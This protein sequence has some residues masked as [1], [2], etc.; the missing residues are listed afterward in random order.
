LVKNSSDK[1]QGISLVALAIFV[2][3]DSSLSA[4]VAEDAVELSHQFLEIPQLGASPL[5]NLGETLLGGYPDVVNN[6]YCT[7][8]Q[9]Q[10]PVAFNWLRKSELM[11][12]GVEKT[13]N[14]I[15]QVPSRRRCSS[16]DGASS[17]STGRGIKRRVG[18]VF[19]CRGEKIKACAANPL[20]G[21]AI[22]SHLGALNL[23][24]IQ[25]GRIL[26]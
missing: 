1:E 3:K 8:Q 12:D 2:P 21:P 17:F 25:A 10:N 6:F 14:E 15:A 5:M 19:G 4:T 24:E 18:V 22:Q 9:E 16:P 7:S 11:R 20:P 23:I 26:R 13:E